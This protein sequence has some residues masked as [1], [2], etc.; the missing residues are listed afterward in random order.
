MPLNR[1]EIYELLRSQPL[2][3]TLDQAQLESLLDRVR[4]VQLNADQM[5]F[6][7]GDPAER[8][9]LVIEGQ[10]KLFRTTPDGDE[11]VVHIMRR[12]RTFAEAAMFMSHNSYPVGAQAMGSTRLLAISSKAYMDILRDSP[13]SCFRLL[14]DLSHR[15]HQR[16]DELETVSL[17]NANHRVARYLARQY[18][19]RA[20][21]PDRTFQ[22]QVPKQV[23]ASQLA[24]KPETFSRALRS[25]SEEGIISVTGKTV[26]V[27]DPKALD[28]L[29]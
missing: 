19:E 24:M 14:A 23:I 26:T 15:L 12:G 27:I 29:Y 16:L 17:Q 9:F 13:E 25:L 4:T 7:P 6:Q 8:F 28:A 1:T 20:H 2:F 5:L 10:I 21:G 22:L 11:K 3:A 18:T